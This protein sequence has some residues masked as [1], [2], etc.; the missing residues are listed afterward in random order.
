MLTRTKKHEYTNQN[1]KLIIIWSIG[2]KLPKVL[3]KKKPMGIQGKQIK[4][5][6]RGTNQ[7]S[8][9]SKQYSKPE[10][11]RGLSKVFR[12]LSTKKAV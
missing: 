5:P 3:K 11:T 7:I 6:M 1:E 8:E 9:V 12:V 10:D 4:S 2:L